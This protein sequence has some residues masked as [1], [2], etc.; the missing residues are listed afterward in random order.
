MTFTVQNKMINGGES[1]YYDSGF[2]NMLEVFLARLINSSGTSR[3]TVDHGLVSR[4]KSDFYG[5]L[6]A[7]DYPIPMHLRWIT[8]RMNGFT[9]PNQFAS[10]L[11]MVDANDDELHETKETFTVIIPD[12]D[13]IETLRSRYLTSTK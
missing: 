5:L 1:I 12:S 8:M 13:Y 6:G 9:N 4:Y 3:V 10:N 7:L 2:C 11:R